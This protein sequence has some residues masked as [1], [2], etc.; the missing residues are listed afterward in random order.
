MAREAR[1]LTQEDRLT[2]FRQATKSLPERYAAQ[3]E[4]GMTDADLTAALEAALGIWGG[5]CGL[6]KMDVVHQASELKIW[7]GWHFVNHVTEPP[8][9]KGAA[10][11]AIAREIYGIAN[12]DDRQMNLL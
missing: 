4:N 2:A 10:T 1:P 3:I 11:L 8:L 5:S 7:G 9:F 12:P 6:G